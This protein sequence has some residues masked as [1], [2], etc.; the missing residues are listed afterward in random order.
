MIY[1]IYFNKTSKVKIKFKDKSWSVLNQ[2]LSIS[3]LPYDYKKLIILQMVLFNLTMSWHYEI[4]ICYKKDV[5]YSIKNNL[6]K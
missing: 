5:I 4:V 3:N 1:I 2:I 6:I